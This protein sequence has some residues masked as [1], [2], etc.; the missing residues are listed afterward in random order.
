[1]S[2][3]DIE[4]EQCPKLICGIVETSLILNYIRT[5]QHVVLARVSCQITEL[6]LYC[7]LVVVTDINDAC[8][9]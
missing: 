4:L 2:Q 1:M 7:K 3:Q 5:S 6:I 8:Y 9:Q